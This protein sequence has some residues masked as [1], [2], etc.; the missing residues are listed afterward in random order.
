MSNPPRD[1][2]ELVSLFLPV[3]F[4]ED[5]SHEN[6]LDVLAASLGAFTA[7]VTTKITPMSW[8]ERTDLCRRVAARVDGEFAAWMVEAAFRSAEGDQE[9]LVG[10]DPQKLAGIPVETLAVLGTESLSRDE[11][12]ALR[13]PAVEHARALRPAL[14][15]IP[16]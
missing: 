8:S 14:E 15:N 13:A 10:A 2:A 16:R 5:L 6:E 4:G 12:E 3:K 1:L 11:A 9:A 7:A